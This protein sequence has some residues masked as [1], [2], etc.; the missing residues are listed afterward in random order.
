MEKR[1]MFN[2][3]TGDR[4]VL[5]SDGSRVYEKDNPAEYKRLRRNEKARISRRLMDDAAASVGLVKCRVNGKTFY[6]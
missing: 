1:F 3:L 5:F 6:E 2:K 4:F